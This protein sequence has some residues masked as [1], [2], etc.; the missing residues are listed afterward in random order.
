MPP[1]TG[2]IQITLSQT[3]RF[4]GAV[5]VTTPHK[6]ALVDAAKGLGMFKSV[7]IPI[8][9]VVENMAYFKCDHG[10]KYYPFGQGGKDRLIAALG[11]NES[12]VSATQAKNMMTE[13]EIKQC[14]YISLPLTSESAGFVSQSDENENK[15]QDLIELTS[16]LVVSCPK[17]ESV[18]IYHNLAQ[19]IIEQTFLLQLQTLL[20][21]SIELDSTKNSLKL[22]Y[23]GMNETMDYIL[24]AK[25]LYD[26]N[27][28]DGKKR[29]IS[30]ETSK[31][32]LFSWTSSTP[33]IVSIDLK[34]RYGVGIVFD[35]K[36]S[37]I[38]S[39]EVLKTILLEDTNQL[40]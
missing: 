23:F 31:S 32:S 17:S 39:Y 20:T 2:D 15:S 38:Y 21:P 7:N 1:G 30:N 10:K 16:P 28:N 3:I 22:R 5:V 13:G 12:E 24:T 35:D 29:D 11:S 27:P 8:L 25:Q 34:G 40:I 26:R 9:S 19:N 33:R 4:T 36:R 37:D 18:G 14:P 6:L